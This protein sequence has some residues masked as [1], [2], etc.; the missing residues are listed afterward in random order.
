MNIKSSL[1]IFLFLICGSLC[2]PQSKSIR[3]LDLSF[4]IQSQS[5]QTADDYSTEDSSTEVKGTLLY[6]Y[7]PH[8]FVFE[9]TSTP[10]TKVL[11][12]ADGA[13]SYENDFRNY[14]P[15]FS[16]IYDTED[17]FLDYF[18]A[19]YNLPLKGFEP[20]EVA[21]EDGLICTIWYYTRVNVYPISYIKV[22][23]DSSSRI[24]KM[25]FY[26]TQ[27][28]L[29]SEIQ[30]SDYKFVSGFYYPSTILSIEHPYGQTFSATITL[31]VKRLNFVMEENLLTMYGAE[32][33]EIDLP[34]Q[35]A[36][37]KKK[38]S[39]PQTPPSAEFRTSA[40]S[41]F[42]NGAFRFYKTFI[43]AQDNS[44]CGYYPSCS[45]Y[46]VDAISKHGLAGFFQGM[47][48]LRRCT[49]NEHK[50]NNYI[51]LENGKHYDPVTD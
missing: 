17:T 29:T 11:L 37:K 48:R 9:I 24:Q 16:S 27:D 33:I 44:S 3:S 43:T 40:S 2:F 12:N 15:D 35:Q 23:T 32:S 47:E 21:P 26:T 22:Y 51:T 19:D 18:A 39:T 41:I 5:D 1:I 14:L 42:V 45:Q 4:S 25:K 13:F 7:N 20:Y 36:L 46:M 6:N 31:D 38:I 30:F 34:E 50:T 10:Q 49:S 8:I 28:E